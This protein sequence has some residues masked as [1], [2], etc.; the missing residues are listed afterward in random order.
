MQDIELRF[1]SLQVLILFKQQSGV[2]ELRIDTFE[3]TLTGKFPEGEV[4]TAIRMFKATIFN[5]QQ[6]AAVSS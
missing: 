1:P 4:V 2:K 5:R 3:K 6:F